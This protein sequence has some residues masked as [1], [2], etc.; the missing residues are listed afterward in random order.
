[1]RCVREILRLKHACG[2]SDRVIAR[3]T[4]VA[5]STVGDYLERA[6]AAGLG[7]PVPATLTDAALEALLFATA[8]TTPGTRRRAEPDWPSI[9]RERRRPGVTLMLLWQEYRTREPEGYGYSRFC[10]L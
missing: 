9:D 3:S 1:M 5:R 4:G 6:A 10:E 8:G 2:A 7:W